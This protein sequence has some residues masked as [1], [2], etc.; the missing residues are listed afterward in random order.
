[1]SMIPMGFLNAVVA[2]GVGAEK[3]RRWIGT[4]FLVQ[5]KEKDNSGKATIYLITNKHVI[6]NQM[7]L[8][9]RFNATVGSLVKDYE[10]HLYNPDGTY[11]YT[12]HPNKD[13]DVIA[14]KINPNA[15][16]NDSSIWAAFD[17]D[18]NALTLEQ[19]QATGVQEG[20][21]V[22]ALGFP[23]GLVDNI[24]TPI[25]RLGCISRVFDAF[26]LK[27]GTPCYL[28]DAQVFPGN[29]GGPIINRPEQMAIAGT[30]ANDRA[31]LIGILSAY[32]P[33]EDTLVSL[34]TGKPRMVQS[35]NSGLTIVH[36]VDRIKEVV[37]LEWKRVEDLLIRQQ[38]QSREPKDTT[39]QEEAV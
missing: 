35:E 8:Y 21:L 24:K 28:V 23:M 32:L 5:R 26:L 18:D 19:M 6:E 29:S 4:G 13:S 3:E 14:L 10:I 30:V 38:G 27:Q 37:E 16:I 15:L 17:L 22:Y 7:L 25:C 1:M 36:P 2:L 33:Y 20:S 12:A 11:C 9:I 39:P 34:Q 31:N